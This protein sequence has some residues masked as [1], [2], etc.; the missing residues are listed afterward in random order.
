MATDR[1]IKKDADECY[2][3][4]EAHW[5]PYW[6]EAKLD[7]KF[8][9]GDHWSARDKAYLAAND[10]EALTFG[11]CRRIVNLVTGYEQKN[12]LALKIDPMESAD[13]KTASQLSAI[14]LNNMLNGGYMAMSSA[15][16][17]GPVITGMNLIEAWVDRSQDL[18]NGDIK[19]RRLPYNRFV[20]DPTFTSRDLDDDCGFIYLRDYFSKDQVSSLLPDREDDI[21]ILIGG[22]SDSKFNQYYPLKGKNNE[23]NLKYDRFYTV[24]YRPYQVLID[25]QTGKIIPLDDKDPKIKTLIKMFMQRFPNLKL[26]K[27]R[28]KGVD[29]HI[30]VEGELMYSGLDSSGL[31]EYPF[32]LEAGYYTPEEDDP[33]YQIQ[34][35]MRCMR[36]PGTEI[37]RRRSMVLDMLD[38]VIRQGWKVKS[39]SVVNP[40]AMYSSGSEVLWMDENAQMTDA[41]RLNPPL[42]PEGIFRFME[43]MDKDHDEMP[44]VNNEMLGS[45]ENDIEVAAI[46][47]KLRSANGLTTLQGIFNAHRDAKRLLGRK[48]VKLIQ[49]NYTPDKIQRILGEPP[50]QEFYTKDFAKYDCNPVEGVLTDSQRQM[51]YTQ[52]AGWKKA[53]APIPWSE[54]I[55]YAPLEKKDSLK[56]AMQQQEQSQQ[57]QAQQDMM[58][59]KI[60]NDLLN[61]QK[62]Q[63]IASGQQKLSQAVEDRSGARLDNARAV[64]ELQGID[65]NNFMQTLELLKSMAEMLAGN[66][67][68]QQPQQIVP[69]QQQPMN[70]IM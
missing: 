27:G 12:L 63:S 2:A 21:E 58:T 17:F 65:I 20:L 70:T 13:E 1:D 26:L 24:S 32:V 9:E 29:L 6:Q 68:P 38:G 66:Q 30:F 53:G 45:V 11:K 50:T 14:V 64:K 34:G 15:F 69:Q 16:E 41:E 23:Y 25:T 42:I 67:Q 22:S 43:I 37:D 54:I 19:F 48:Q 4:G 33:K 56:K 35:L 49:A 18:L 28:R 10:R 46:L 5:S 59:Q 3:A 31:D 55:E 36:D 62:F 47:A 52:L 60:T 8:Y 7:L 40:E 39:G 44:G 57:Q 61:A 51:Y